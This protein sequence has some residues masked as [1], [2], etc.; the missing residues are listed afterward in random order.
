MVSK[1]FTLMCMD[2][3]T[4]TMEQIHPFVYKC[5][6]CGSRQYASNIIITGAKR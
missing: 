5:T 3:E 4:E 2:C 6:T 1:T